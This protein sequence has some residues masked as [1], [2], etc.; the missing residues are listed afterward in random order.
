MH[1]AR[2]P[3]CVDEAIV[4]VPLDIS[5]DPLEVP[6]SVVRELP[7]VPCGRPNQVEMPRPQRC[8]ANVAPE[9]LNKLCL[10]VIRYRRHVSL[11]CLVGLTFEFTR[12]RRR[13]K[14][15]VASRVQ[16]WVGPHTLRQ[17]GSPVL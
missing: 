16:R 9:P 4:D 7:V 8:D 5:N 17:N 12:S 3:R 1:R 11:W 10:V 2:R 6:V 14:P 13:A 15:A